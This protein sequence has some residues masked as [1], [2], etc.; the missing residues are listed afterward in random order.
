MDNITQKESQALKA[1]IRRWVIHNGIIDAFD[2]TEDEFVNAVFALCCTQHLKLDINETRDGGY[3]L[4]FGL[5]KK[6]S[7]LLEHLDEIYPD[8]KPQ[9]E[10]VRG[11]LQ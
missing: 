4:S 1:V 11:W 8:V 7:A 3:V 10:K 5:T 2:F 6:G 9:F